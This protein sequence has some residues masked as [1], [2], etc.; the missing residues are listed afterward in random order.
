MKRLLPLLALV[1]LVVAG[2][3]G[4]SGTTVTNGG[5]V[6]DGSP[7]SGAAPDFTLHDQKGAAVS[8]SSDR[9]SWVFV[10][11][12]YVHCPDVCPLIATHLNRAL[13]SPTAKAAKLKVLAVSVDPKGDTPSAVA[14]YVVAHHLRP[15]FRYLI[16]S[17]AQ[18]SPVW[19]GYHVAA[20]AG[21]KQTITH[22]AFEVLVDPQG[23][24]RYWF[25]SSATASDFV[26][27]LQALGAN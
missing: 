4:T 16:G 13:G 19:K 10:T 14:A 17:Q 3:G 5:A 8:L 24:E 11:F 2:C 23:K 26:R 25:D 1:C 21:A 20:V 22:G 18:L 27:E 9:G 6:N 15:A 7:V 12:L